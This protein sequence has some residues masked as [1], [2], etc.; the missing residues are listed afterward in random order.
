MNE[1]PHPTSL[2]SATFPIGEGKADKRLRSQSAFSFGEGKAVEQ[3]RSQSA[4]SSGEGKA[5]ERLRSKPAFPFG[6]GARRADEV[7][8]RLSSLKRI[9]TEKDAWPKPG[10]PSVLKKIQ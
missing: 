10:V 3:P 6:E 7:F 9:N 4:F 1:G 8:V 5:V 2:R